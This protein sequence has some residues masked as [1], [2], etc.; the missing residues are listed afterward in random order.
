MVSGADSTSL[1]IYG[2]SHISLGH[3]TAQV[4]IL[5]ISYHHLYISFHVT[6]WVACVALYVF[7]QYSDCKSYINKIKIMINISG[8]VEDTLSVGHSL[9]EESAV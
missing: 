2:V 9:L 4:R 5:G 1:A 6:L 7:I 3:I 8:W